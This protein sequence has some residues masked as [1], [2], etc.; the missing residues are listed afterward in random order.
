[1]KTEVKNENW[2]MATHGDELGDEWQ[3]PGHDAVGFAVCSIPIFKN[4]TGEVVAFVTTG[5]KVDS[6]FLDE[7]D[8]EAL[9]KRAELM[10][11]APSMYRALEAIAQYGILLR[12]GG[13]APHD[14]KDLSAALEQC[15]ELAQGVLK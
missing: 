14:L 13:A 6:I 9:D 2:R 5:R 3:S 11:A 7:D 10:A 8:S 12:A 15:V 4:E 1:M